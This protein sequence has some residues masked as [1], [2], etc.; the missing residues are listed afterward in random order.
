M[1]LV[2]KNWAIWNSSIVSIDL[3][4]TIFSLSRIILSWSSI[5]L[6]VE[7][8]S[9]IYLQTENS[10]HLK[11]FTWKSF[12]IPATES[13]TKPFW[14]KSWE[15]EIATLQCTV[16]NTI[17]LLKSSLANKSC[18]AVALVCCMYMKLEDSI[19]FKQTGRINTVCSETRSA[20]GILLS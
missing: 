16:F 10:N 4:Q 17:T 19:P 18:I 3:K 7:D 15:R 5:F 8:L 6:M 1:L 12:I 13:Q 9:M 2:L 20:S 14:Y 11:K